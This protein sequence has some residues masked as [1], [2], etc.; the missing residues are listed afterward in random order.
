M[1]LVLNNHFNLLRFPAS[2]K[3]VYSVK[4]SCFFLYSSF[5]FLFYVSFRY[6]FLKDT[7]KISIMFLKSFFFK[8][9]LKQL[10]FLSTR[11]RIFYFFNLLFGLGLVGCCSV[12]F[13]WFVCVFQLAYIPRFKDKV[14][15]A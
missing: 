1:S 4:M 5:V 9:F 14:L 13:D 12:Y 11:L 7:D 8:S 10:K 3:L 6:F 15:D 2:V